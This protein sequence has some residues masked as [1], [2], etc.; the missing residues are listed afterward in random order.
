MNQIEVDNM[1]RDVYTVQFAFYNI[2]SHND[3][4]NAFDEP[5]IW[6]IDIPATTAIEAIDNAQRI[7]TIARSEIMVD[8]FTG[9]MPDN[10][11]LSLHEIQEIINT[12]RKRNVFKSWLMIQPTSIQCT[13]KADLDTLKDMTYKNIDKIMSDVGNEAEEF[14]KEIKNDNA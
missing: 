9:T 14:L 1:K 6:Q 8:V 5:D 7:L 10:E 2:D 12:A 13:L 4:V 3:K 11:S